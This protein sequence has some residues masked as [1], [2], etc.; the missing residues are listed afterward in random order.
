MHHFRVQSMY[1]Y[2][3]GYPNKLFRFPSPDRPTFFQSTIWRKHNRPIFLE[4]SVKIKVFN[5]KEL[6]N[7][8]I[9]FWLLFLLSNRPTQPFEWRAMGNETFYW[10]GLTQLES[11]RS[12]ITIANQT[13]H[14]FEYF[15]NKMT[16]MKNI[17]LD[18]VKV[19]STQ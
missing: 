14:Y 8:E 19:L 4:I 16:Y 7:F 1:Q 15:Y 5:L 17:C 11:R 9:I 13:L 12:T 10:D 18:F 2:Q 6:Y 3:S